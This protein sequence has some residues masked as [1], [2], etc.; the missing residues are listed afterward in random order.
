MQNLRTALTLH[1]LL[2]AAIVVSLLL[3]LSIFLGGVVFAEIGKSD[4]ESSPLETVAML[5]E[6]L[7]SLEILA[8]E[9]TSLTDQGAETRA[10]NIFALAEVDHNVQV[11]SLNNESRQDMIGR[12]DV[13]VFVTTLEFRGARN[14]ILGVLRELPMTFQGNLLMDQINVHGT[15]DEWNIRLSIQQIIQ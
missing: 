9:A 2:Q 7:D 8:Q 5:Q 13:Q 15:A 4:Q 12:Q 14:D 10:L 11:W 1:M 3:N 6:Q